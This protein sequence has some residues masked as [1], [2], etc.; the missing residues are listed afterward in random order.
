ML[1]KRLLN[2]L[3]HDFNDVKSRHTSFLECGF[4]ECKVLQAQLYNALALYWR[5]GFASGVHIQKKVVKL[6]AEFAGYMGTHSSLRMGEILD[7]K[8]V[9]PKLADGMWLGER[10]VDEE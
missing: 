3:T 5:V 10:C 1:Q 9:K 7:L 6:I 8:L 2:A 4:L